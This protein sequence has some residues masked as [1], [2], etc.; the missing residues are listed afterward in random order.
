[1]GVI[2]YTTPGCPFCSKA[3]EFFSAR[4]IAFSEYDVRSNRARAREMAGA[5]PK[6][7]VPTMIINGRVVVGFVPELMDEALKRAPPPKREAAVQNLI[8]D[9]FES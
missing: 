6:G 2:I 1:M 9:P 3:K 7:T 8:F 5:N 4:G